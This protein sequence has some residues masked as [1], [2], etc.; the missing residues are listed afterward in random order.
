MLTLSTVNRV[1]RTCLAASAAIVIGLVGASSASAMTI[2]HLGVKGP[3]VAEVQ[4][5]LHI[6]ANRLYDHRTYLAVRR[7]QARHHLLVD[8]QVGPH[9]WAALHRA[10]AHHTKKRHHSHH[11]R[12][13]DGV[14]RLG[15]KGKRHPLGM[16]LKFGVPVALVTDDAGVARSTL[17]L[18]FR[19][20]VE[21]QGVDYRPLK[22]MVQNSLEYSFADNATNANPGLP[23]ESER[24]DHGQRSS[25]I[26]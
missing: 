19:K 14:L 24:A 22:R 6:R 21:E 17:T 12:R 3:R 8:G 13:S 10:P 1:H 11:R 23:P 15:V 25:R 5:Q 4:R 20:A 2:L 7:F 26:S 18:E 16:Y 9:T